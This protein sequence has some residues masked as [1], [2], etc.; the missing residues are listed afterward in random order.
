MI[1]LRIFYKLVLYIGFAFSISAC[2]SSANQKVLKKTATE[3]TIETYLNDLKAPA[4]YP[5][6]RVVDSRG[7]ITPHVPLQREKLIAEGIPVIE[8]IKDRSVCLEK[9]AWKHKSIY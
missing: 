5:V 7:K 4:N 1:K 3:K 9:Y 2:F 8:G 6:H